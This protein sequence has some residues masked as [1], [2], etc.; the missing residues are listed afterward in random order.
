MRACMTDD[1]G[2]GRYEESG[3]EGHCSYIE[4]VV[5]EQ[6]S[7][8]LRSQRAFQNSKNRSA[9]C[10]KFWSA[11]FRQNFPIG[12]FAVLLVLSFYANVY[13]RL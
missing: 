5:G 6:A 1:G 9:Y 4:L 12:L 11:L 10:P 3:G 13:V 7:S 8:G 2:R